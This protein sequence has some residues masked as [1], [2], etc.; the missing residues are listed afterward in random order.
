MITVSSYLPKIKT[1][2]EQNISAEMREHCRRVGK[3]AKT[4]AESLGLDPEVA[5][6]AGFAHDCAKELQ[7]TRLVNL[8]KE[9]KL[10][11]I[12]LDYFKITA[13]LHAK[14]GEVIARG[15]F[16]IEDA[17][18]LASIRCH[19]FGEPRMSKIA[20]VVFVAD[21]TEPARK[22]KYAEP[23]R[24]VLAEE[25]LE[26]AVLKALN[27]KLQ[28]A[29]E[30][31]CFIHPSMIETRNYFVRTLSSVSMGTVTMDEELLTKMTNGNFVETLNNRLKSA[32]K[33]GQATDPLLAEVRNYALRIKFTVK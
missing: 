22:E 5:K 31:G 16:G 1:W 17:D 6:V 18:V 24:K 30:N 28:Q 19:T 9:N 7:P 25:G 11:L 15:Q 21:D 27:I 2:Y 12:Q 13:F 4:Y 20:M 3:T 23:V 29:I 14:V 33:E 8:A 10:P 32:V 26:K